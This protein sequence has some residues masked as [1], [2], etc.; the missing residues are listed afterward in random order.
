MKKL[1]ILITAISLS[2]CSKKFYPASVE[3]NVRIETRYVEIERIVEKI[4]D[5]TIFV[6]IPT[7]SSKRFGVADSS[8]LETSV[9][10]SSA[11]IDDE[12]KLNHTLNNKNTSL[13]ANVPLIERE[14]EREILR[15]STSLQDRKETIIVE[16]NKLTW[17][18]QTQ[19]KGFWLLLAGWLLFIAYKKLRKRLNFLKI[20]KI[21]K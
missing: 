4:R 20:W 5:T 13:P 10:E 1:L 3:E 9:E 19:K 16:V 8:H 14:T 2:S 12:G 11:W 17:W 6:L 7:E 15:D 18:Q 21:N